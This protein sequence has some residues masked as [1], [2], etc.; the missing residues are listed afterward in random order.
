[1]IEYSTKMYKELLEAIVS[2]E[3]KL[4]L[5]IRKARHKNDRPFVAFM[6]YMKMKKSY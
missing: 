1:M 4:Y 3:T 5:N 6:L 2:L